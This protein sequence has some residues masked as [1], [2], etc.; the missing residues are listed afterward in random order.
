MLG[1]TVIMGE[2]ILLPTIILRSFIV[3]MM[4]MNNPVEPANCIDLIIIPVDEIVLQNIEKG[5]GQKTLHG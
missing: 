4:T 5:L 2:D 1:G 3:T